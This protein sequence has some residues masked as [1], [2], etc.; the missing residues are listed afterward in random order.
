MKHRLLSG[1]LVNQQCERQLHEA[2]IQVRLNK[3]CF[4]RFS[5]CHLHTLDFCT[6]DHFVACGMLRM[7]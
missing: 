5:L 3:L 1:V 6:G 7:F 4:F 2:I